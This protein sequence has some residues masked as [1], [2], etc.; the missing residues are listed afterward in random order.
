MTTRVG[1]AQGVKQFDLGEL[2]G[3]CHDGG[4]PEA[5]KRPMQVLE[6]G[7]DAVTV[8]VENGA[9]GAHW[10][11]SD[12]LMRTRVVGGVACAAGDSDADRRS[13]FP[14]SSLLGRSLTDV[15]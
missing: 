15:A 1:I 11:G 9:D 3:D 10:L 14:I 13:T 12:A 4:K 2:G 8:V 6:V 7:T 5:V